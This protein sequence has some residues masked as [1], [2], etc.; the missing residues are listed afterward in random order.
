MAQRKNVGAINRQFAVTTDPSCRNRW[1]VEAA[2]DATAL[3]DRRPA[4]LQSNP[5]T[6]YSPR[7]VI[8]IDNTRVDHSGKLIKDVGWVWDPAHQRRVIAHDYLISNYV[9]PSGSHYPT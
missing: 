5:K 7:G 6:R 2:W 3:N 1:R 4:W 8:A 9:R